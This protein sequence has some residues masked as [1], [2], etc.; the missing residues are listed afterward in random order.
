MFHN[1]NLHKNLQFVAEVVKVES[2]SNSNKSIKFK[3]EKNLNDNNLS[4]S[5]KVCSSKKLRKIN[6]NNNYNSQHCWTIELGLVE[7]K[8]QKILELWLMKNRKKFKNK[9][10]CNKKNRQSKILFNKLSKKLSFHQ[11]SSLKPKP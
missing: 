7:I 5:N 6:N 11:D 1:N 4:N 10:S 2:R 8:L 9:N 3:R